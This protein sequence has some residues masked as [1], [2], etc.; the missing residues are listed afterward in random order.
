MRDFQLT[1]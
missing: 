1:I